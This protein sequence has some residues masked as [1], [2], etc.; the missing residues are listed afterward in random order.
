MFKKLLEKFDDLLD[1]ANHT[2]KYS[3]MVEEYKQYL[4]SGSKK[5]FGEWTH[6]KRRDEFEQRWEQYKEENNICEHVESG[7]K[8]KWGFE[9]CSKCGKEFDPNPDN[10]DRYDTLMG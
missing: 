7:K 6:E 9:I 3:P 5:D 10:P 1:R 2:G 4:K 8:S